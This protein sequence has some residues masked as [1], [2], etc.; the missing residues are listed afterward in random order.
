MLNSQSI[1]FFFFNLGLLKT[2]VIFLANIFSGVLGSPTVSTVLCL[3]NP[4]KI[5]VIK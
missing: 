1:L 4:R 2:E 3:T 5:I